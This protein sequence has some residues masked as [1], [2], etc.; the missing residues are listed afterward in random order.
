MK[1]AKLFRNGQSQAVRLPQEF[2]FK[3][4]EVLIKRMGNAV[5]LIPEQ[6][7]WDSLIQSLSCFSDDFMQERNQ[8]KEKQNRSD[9]FD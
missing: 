1:K 6:H 7:S 8:P 2:R 5:V 4:N 3:G 9:V